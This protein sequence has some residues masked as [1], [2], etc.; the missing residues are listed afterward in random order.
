[1]QKIQSHFSLW[2]KLRKLGT[3][4]A[5]KSQIKNAAQRAGEKKSVKAPS[6]AASSNYSGMNSV[7]NS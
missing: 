5:M 2:L 1:M 6:F 3:V 4:R 7:G